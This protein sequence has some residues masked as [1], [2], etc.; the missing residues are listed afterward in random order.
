MTVYAKQVPP[1]YQESSLFWDESA[2]ENLEIFGN[3][4]YNRRTTALFDRLPGILDDLA[5]QWESFTNGRPD[6]Y[7]TWAEALADIAPPD[8]RAEY[9]REER[10]T[11][12]PDLLNRYIQDGDTKE[13]LIDV[14]TIITDR[15]WDWCTLRGC[16]QRDWQYCIYPADEWDGDSLERLE[17]DY[18]NTGTEWIIHDDETP[19]ESPEDINGYSLYCYSWND[20]GLREEIANAAG[21]TPEEVK[22]YEFA[23]FTRS[24]IY[25]EV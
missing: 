25:E 8:G 19:P 17:M 23:G 16:C 5:Y 14:L 10:R 18:F 11:E 20:A 13:I 2:L 3:R 7:D 15:A 22:L 4:D 9:T 24:A 21:C 6:Y 12:W 1:E